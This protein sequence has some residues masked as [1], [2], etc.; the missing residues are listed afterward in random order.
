[1][2]LWLPVTNWQD[3]WVCLRQLNNR[4]CAFWRVPYSSW[5]TLTHISWYRISIG[6]TAFT[7]CG[8]ILVRNTSIS[9]HGRT[10][11][12]QPIVEAI[13][14]QQ[15]GEGITSGGWTSADE[16]ERPLSANRS[17]HYV[18]WS[19]TVKS[20]GVQTPRG[21]LCPCMR[22]LVHDHR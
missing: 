12:Y 10:L 19:W 9:C 1:M 21:W 7:I 18:I 4:S 2:F 13:V 17:R 11:V 20:N 3:V 8:T 16:P 6:F 15:L 22:T 14:K 5:S